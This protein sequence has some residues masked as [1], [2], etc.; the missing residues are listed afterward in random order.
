MEKHAIFSTLG[1]LATIQLINLGLMIS[2]A[3]DKKTDNIDYQLKVKAVGKNFD[4]RFFKEGGD[5]SVSRNDYPQVFKLA[6]SDY[7]KII[8]L[9]AE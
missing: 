4:Y 5:Y 8:G 7:E 1:T 6:H 9:T 3:V 2:E